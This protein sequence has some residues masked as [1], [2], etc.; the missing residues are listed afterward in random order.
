MLRA[1]HNAD[2]LQ[3]SLISTNYRFPSG[4]TSES[5]V[6]RNNEQME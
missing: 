3:S 6:W 4:L 2:S 5:R 1:L